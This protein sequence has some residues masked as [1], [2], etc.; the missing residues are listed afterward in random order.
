M[1]PNAAT[2]LVRRRVALLTLLIVSAIAASASQIGPSAAARIAA[3]VNAHWRGAYDILV[4]P[5]GGQ[6]EAPGTGGS[7]LVE[8]NFVALAGHGGIT[9]EQV[10]SIASIAGVEFAA[11]I[12]WVGLVT[13]PTTAP[14]IIIDEL[15]TAPTVYSVKVRISTSDGVNDHL[16]LEEVIRVVLAPPTVP[17]GEPWVLSDI[18]SGAFGRTPEGTWEATLSLGHALPQ[19]QSPL[20][21][22]DPD[23]ERALLGDSGAILDPLIALSDRDTLTIGTVSPDMVLPE[24]PSIQGSIAS[25]QAL[26]GAALD[27][28]VFP[29]VVSAKTYAPLRASLEL[30]QIGQVLDELPDRSQG[31]AVALE[32]AVDAAGSGSTVVGSSSADWAEGLRALRMNVLGITWSGRQPIEGNIPV[33]FGGNTSYQAILTRPPTYRPAS[34]DSGVP[35]FRISP[36]GA[37]GPGGPLSNDWIDPHSLVDPDTV[38]VGAE[39]SYRALSEGDIPVAGDFVQTGPLDVPYVLAP[40]GEYDLDS[41]NLPHDPLDYVPYGAYDPPDTKLIADPEGTSVEPVSM[42]PTLNPTGLLS[43]PPMG[44]VD[45]HAAEE[46]RGPA[47]IDAVRV[48]VA[49]ITDY[50]PEAIAK[51]ERVATAISEMGLDAAVVAASSPQTVN[52]YVPAY[53]LS[54]ADTPRDLGWIAQQWTTL[55]AA[56]LVEH[57]LTD[58]NVALILLT[59]IGVAII[60]ASVELITSSI[61]ARESAIL[62]SIGWRRRRIIAWQAGESAVAGLVV[63]VVAATAWLLSGQR[64]WLGL[65]VALALAL[66]FAIFG[67]I[68]S[69]AASQASP[70]GG[71]ASGTLLAGRPVTGVQTYG[72]RSIAARPARSI[73]AIIGIGMSAGAV[74]P[75]IGLLPAVGGRVGPTALAEALA[76][77]LHPYQIALVFLIAASALAC[78]L[79][80]LRSDL[81]S[82]RREFTVLEAIGWTPKRVIRM[83]AWSRLFMAIPAAAGAFIVAGLLATPV[84]GAGASLLTILPVAA[85]LTLLMVGLATVVDSLRFLNRWRP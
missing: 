5:A 10:T 18:G 48:R 59:I 77:R 60:I 2:R 36:L 38:Q 81:E 82:R 55:G 58:T 31:D 15:P 11:P 52:V 84:A 35:A 85:L 76:E 28:P 7:G 49:G 47:P 42:N 12:G 24:Y 80:A 14:A 25:T 22:V 40:V 70:S 78:A 9:P 51:V 20:I 17:G 79:L 16:V 53:D 32:Q 54:T 41:L 61:R 8:P 6:R 3:E 27:R 64:G 43:V 56:V 69:S 26:G 33:F 65:G 72:W 63:A 13:I 68:G 37:V 50:G 1:L 62:A 66:L 67:L 83:V 73:V 74:A 57:E 23:A 29:A 4:R 19:I 34:R 44:I 75:A 21:A 71:Q 30:S 39:Q 46:L 45:I